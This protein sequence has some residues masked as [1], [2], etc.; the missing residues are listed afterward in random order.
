MNNLFLYF[1]ESEF[2]SLSRLGNGIDKKSIRSGGDK[3]LYGITFRRRHL[4]HYSPPAAA[5]LFAYACRP[6]CICWAVGGRSQDYRLSSHSRGLCT[7]FR[8]LLASDIPVGEPKCLASI[9]DGYLF[10]TRI[11]KCEGIIGILVPKVHTFS[12]LFSHEIFYKNNGLWGPAGKAF[13]CYNLPASNKN[14]RD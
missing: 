13:P 1:P 5:T 7:S 2:R 6:W 9:L 11:P 12:Q 4:S 14:K 3:D 10:D 8:E